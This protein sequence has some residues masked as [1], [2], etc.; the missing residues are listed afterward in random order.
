MAVFPARGAA[1][2]VPERC[3][4]VHRPEVQVRPPPMRT[5]VRALGIADRGHR[6]RRPP[7]GPGRGRVVRRFDAPEALD[8]RFHEVRTKSALNRVPA[9]SRLPFD[10]TVNPY[11]GC[12]HACVYCLARDTPILLA[13]GRTRAIAD[14]RVGDEIYGTV[15]EGRY[16]RYVK[17]EV[18]DHWSTIKPAFRSC[19]R[20]DGARRE[21]RP[22]LPDPAWLEAR[23]RERARLA[24]PPTPDAQRRARG[25]RACSRRLG[26]R[27]LPAR[28][29]LRDD[30][31]RRSPRLVRLPAS[32]AEPRATSIASGSRWS[33]TRRCGA[34]REYLAASTVETD[35]FAVRE[36]RCAAMRAIRDR[37]GAGGRADPR[38]HRV[39]A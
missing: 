33:T 11:R 12:S 9:V 26:G 1:P 10:W 19:S 34:S 8:M 25:R 14:L 13:D 35:E 27:G 38:A 20:R 36:P 21:R 18:L 4:P 28:L 6:R 5:C 22:P 17:T 24:A 31:R 7:P 32:A 3:A 30:P 15:R 16:R 39:A 37:S 29:P 23:H 2:S